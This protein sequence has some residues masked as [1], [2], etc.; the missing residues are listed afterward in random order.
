MMYE[1]A[2]AV[3]AAF[4][5]GYALALRRGRRCAAEAAP[6]PAVASEA[7]AAVEVCVAAVPEPVLI[8]DARDHVVFANAAAGARLL[9]EGEPIGRDAAVLVRSADFVELLRALRAGGAVPAV[10]IAVRSG[11]RSPE[12]TLALSAGFLPAAAGY[13]PGAVVLVFS[14]LT[15]LRR[16]E[17]VRREF[18]ANVSHDLRTPVTIVKGYVQTLAEDFASM[19]ESDRLR[20]MEKIRR[21]TERLHALLESLLELAG[22]EG[23]AAPVL[24]RGVLHH[25]VTEAVDML[26]DRLAAAGLGIS[27]DLAADD[28]AV[29]VDAEAMGRVV[30]NLL[31]NT[32]RYATGATRVRLSTAPDAV[33]GGL[34]LR[35][36]DDGPG[37]PEGEYA[38]VFRRFYRTEKSRSQA[39]GGLGLGLSIVKRLV[40]T[41]GGEIRAEASRPKGFAV[42]IDLPPAP[43][44][45]ME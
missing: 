45:T 40:K 20:F 26:S 5:C 13:G 42:V 25:A 10:E 15:R 4:G 19:D 33:T 14:D 31:E 29:A 21:N 37:V 35:V 3:L 18:V 34:T 44:D 16:L 9:P 6:A 7:R 28:A 43:A 41:Q 27:L 2:V 11:L 39:H 8:L 36:A 24:R 12:R 23:D 1:V 38:K 17:S 30:R 32:L 22:A